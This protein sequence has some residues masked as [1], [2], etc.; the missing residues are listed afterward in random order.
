MRI[1][2]DVRHMIELPLRRKFVRGGIGGTMAILVAACEGARPTGVDEPSNNPPVT[3]SP[4]TAMVALSDLV[5]RSYKGFAGGLYRDGNEPPAAHTAAGRERARLVRPLDAAG[6]PSTTGKYVLL[7]IGMSNTTQEFCSQGSGLPCDP[8]T[9]AGKAAADPTVNHSSLVIVN[10][11]SGGQDASVW[12]S[13]TEA[14]YDRVRDTRLAP[15]GLT[16]R[17]VQVVWIKQAHSGPRSALPASDADAYLMERDLG[18]ILRA[19]RVRY[20]NIRQVF[21]SSRI[22][23]GFATTALNPEP[24]AYESGFSVKWLIDAQ[25]RQMSSAAA[26]P[27]AGDLRYDSVAPWA[28]WGPYLWANGTRARSDGLTWIQ[29]DFQSDGTHPGQTAEEKV[30]RMLLEFFKTSQFTRCWFLASGGVC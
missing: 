17:Q 20:P 6:N 10:G 5:G 2:N 27:V 4:D 22:Y 7:S 15:L 28:A 16:E 13:P 25:A 9:F 21:L 24:Y 3:T 11:A 14:N 1:I 23:A 12:D 19:I 29:A 30:G 18:S 8:W 26:D